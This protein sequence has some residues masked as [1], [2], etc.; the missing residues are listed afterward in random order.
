MA[1]TAAEL[2]EKLNQTNQRL[3]LYYAAERK[4]LSGQSYR[5]GSRE[6][7]RANLQEVLDQIAI[8]ERQKQELET[9]LSTGVGPSKR[10]AVR[11]LYRDL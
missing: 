4:I 8:L 7:T 3:T 5:I 10:K 6:M 2:T 1:Y 9:A 11:V